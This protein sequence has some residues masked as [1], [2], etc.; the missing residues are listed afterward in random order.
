[1]GAGS[2]LD[3]WLPET[4]VHTYSDYVA[5]WPEVQSQSTWWKARLAAAVDEQY[6]KLREYAADV[7]V[8]SQ[9]GPESAPKNS[10][11]GQD[12]SLIVVEEEKPGACVRCGSTDAAAFPL[13]KW[14]LSI[15][16]R[17]YRGALGVSVFIEQ[18]PAEAVPA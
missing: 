16:G 15:C 13:Y 2:E 5:A 3:R 12:D 14:R 8:A 4:P 7:G 17:C 18:V 11:G 1:M 10:G 9:T 6:G